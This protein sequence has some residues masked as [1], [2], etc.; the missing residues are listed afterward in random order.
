[1]VRL[2]FL[3]LVS[4]QLS[5]SAFERHGQ[6]ARS[7]SMGGTS[8]GLCDDVWGMF[9]NPSALA[10]IGQ[11]EAGFFY[12]PQPFGLPELADA[13]FVVASGTP[14]GSVGIAVQQFGS[15]LYRE[16]TASLTYART[17]ESFSAG[18]ATNLY[19]V[20]IERYGSAKS[21]GFDL[22]MHVKLLEQLRWGISVQNI[23]AP[24]IGAAREKLPQEFLVGMAYVPDAHVRL[25]FDLQKQTSFEL[26]P[27]FGFEYLPAGVIALRAGFS[28]EPSEISGGVG[29]R[30]SSFQFDYAVVHHQELGWTQHGSLSLRFGGSDD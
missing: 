9:L 13:G 27:K 16:I 23:N 22:G 5:F 19:A 2:L 12:S 11:P 14:F 8:A 15:S 28:G 26:S 24:T 25:A 7:K 30:L 1:M 4:F 18:I 10:Q 3:T 6:G 20:S 29:V 21:V 17:F